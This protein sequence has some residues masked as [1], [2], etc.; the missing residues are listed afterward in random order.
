LVDIQGDD[1][2]LHYENTLL[3]LLQDSLMDKNG[4]IARTEWLPAEEEDG[5]QEFYEIPE[6]RA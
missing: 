3:A 6:V 2:M 5:S 1:F 4:N